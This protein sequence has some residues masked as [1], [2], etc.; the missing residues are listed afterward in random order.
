MSKVKIKVNPGGIMPTQTHF[1][2]GFT[3]DLI[4]SSNPLKLVYQSGKCSV[5]YE[6][7]VNVKAPKDNVMVIIPR[8]FIAGL[9]ATDSGYCRGNGPKD[10]EVT[11]EF[12][13]DVDCQT[14]PQKGDKVGTLL[15]LEVPVH[16][17]DLEIEEEW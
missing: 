15:L 13:I 9:D 7:S 12:D 8:S 1:K 17:N 2:S 11:Y 16:T 5:K 10:I 6:T 14:L 3:L 4:A